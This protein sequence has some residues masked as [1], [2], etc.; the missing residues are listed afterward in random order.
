MAIDA[1]SAQPLLEPDRLQKAWRLHGLLWVFT[2]FVALMSLSIG[3]AGAQVRAAMAVWVETGQLD[4]AARIILFDIRLPRLALGLLIGAALAVG[5][6]VMQGLFRNPLAD[7][8]LVGVS[9]GAGLGAIL[10]IV[11]GG[12]LP[13]AIIDS[14]GAYLVPIAAFFGGWI[15]TLLLYRVSTRRGRTS[16][17][18]MLLAGIA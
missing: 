15:S 14:V 12:L 7:P 3:A 17:A 9:A 10:A 5:G 1:A 2:A 13:L 6:A 8:G 4:P 16:V 18:T 11:L